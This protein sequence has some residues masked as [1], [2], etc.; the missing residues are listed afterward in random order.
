[1][2]KRKKKYRP[3]GIRR[4]RGR[5]G[6]F[7][8]TD[9]QYQGPWE[10]AIIMRDMIEQGGEAS[11][12]SLNRAYPMRYNMRYLPAAMHRMSLANHIRKAGGSYK[13]ANPRSVYILRDVSRAA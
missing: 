7:A 13:K 9:Y 5:Y 12:R 1:M 6:T 11:P 8:R 4:L 10:R 2:A 3:I